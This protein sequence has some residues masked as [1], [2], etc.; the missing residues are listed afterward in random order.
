MAIIQ[1]STTGPA[2]ESNVKRVHII[3]IGEDVSAGELSSAA[4]SAQVA[5][6]DVIVLN[7]SPFHFVSPEEGV[8]SHEQAHRFKETIVYLTVGRDRVVWWSE[9][10]FRITSIALA[11]HANE[12]LVA[13]E[14]NPPTNPA[15][16]V[17]FQPPVCTA[18]KDAADRVLY[19]QARSE[20][21]DQRAHGHQYKMSFTIGGA[22]VDPDMFCGGG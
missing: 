14:T 15:A 1:G 19:W 6:T 20:V 11:G 17:P 18:V 16:L 8:Q 2:A 9:K 7:G 3:L 12:Q 10:E 4:A 22:N 13:A 21:P 5:P